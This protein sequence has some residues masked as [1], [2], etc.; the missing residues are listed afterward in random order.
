MESKFTELGFQIIGISPDQPSKI[1]ET[2]G[3]QNVRFTLLSDSSMNASKAFGIA[4]DVDSA[5][6]NALA[7]HGIDLNA[8]SGQAHHLLPVPAVF[9]VDPNGTIQFEY[10]NPD[11]RVRSHPELLLTA[12]RLMRSLPSV[13][14]GRE[15]K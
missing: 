10:I 7:Q 4:Y 8:A 6:L 3:K 14:S 5:T 1:R 12:A 9:L 2:I 13:V 11:Y 15:A